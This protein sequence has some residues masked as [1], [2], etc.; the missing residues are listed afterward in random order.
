MT[1]IERMELELREL[2]E[3]ITKGQEFLTRETLRPKFLNSAQMML[4]D[5]QLYHMIQYKEI[6]ED[7][8]K[9]DSEK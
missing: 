1:H 4:L 9:Y 2:D 8:I 5:K 6:L 7:R 3:K